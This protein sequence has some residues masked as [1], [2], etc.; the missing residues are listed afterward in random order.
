[1]VDPISDLDDMLDNVDENGKHK[2]QVSAIRYQ[3]GKDGRNWLIFKFE[4]TDPDDAVEGAEYERWTQDWSHLNKD[5]YEALNGRE[6]SKV[7]TD[8][9]RTLENLIAVGFNEE[10][11]KEIRRN[12][13]SE[14]RQ[15][16]KGRKCWITVQVSDNNGKVFKNVTD[17]QPMI[18]DDGNPDNPPF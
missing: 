12:P 9:R 4:V 15:Q 2:T 17:I 16:A 13:K 8:K 5:D 18:D 14:L 3:N 11:A 1:M 7:R 6:K 10:E